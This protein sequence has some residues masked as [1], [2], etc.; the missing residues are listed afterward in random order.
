[1]GKGRPLLVV[2]LTDLDLAQLGGLKYHQVISIPMIIGS[3]IKERTAIRILPF[4]NTPI[5]KEIRAATAIKK[6]GSSRLSDPLSAM[7]FILVIRH[8]P[9]E[10]FVYFF[11]VGLLGA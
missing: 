3:A 1:M 6:I 5:I 2:L 9:F 10:P 4:M 11:L 8:D 7:V